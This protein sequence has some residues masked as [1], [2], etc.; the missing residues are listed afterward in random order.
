VKILK[1][2]KNSSNEKEMDFELEMLSRLDHPNIIKVFG[3]G[4]DPRR[5]LVMEHLSGGTLDQVL[6]SDGQKAS[7]GLGRLFRTSANTTDTLDIILLALEIANAI[8]YLHEDFHDEAMIIHRGR[9][10]Y[11]S[12]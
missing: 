4:Q 1:G 5:F 6:K 7:E 11:A 2:I 8:K 12:L 3:S 10:I 9:I